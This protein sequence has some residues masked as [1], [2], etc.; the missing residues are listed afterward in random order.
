MDLY[1]EKLKTQ[2]IEKEQGKQLEKAAAAGGVRCPHCGE[3]NEPGAMFCENCGS[4]IESGKC[5]SCGA[6]LPA[7]ADFCEK[8]KSYVAK[9][10]C[11]FC[12][13]SMSPEDAFCPE[14]GAPRQGIVCPVCHTHNMFS[15][16]SICG[17]PLTEM[18]S[19]QLRMV[20][21]EP[22]YARM[23]QIASDLRK[24]LHVIPVTTAGQ[25]EKEKRNE[26]LRNRILGLLGRKL[27]IVQEEVPGAGLDKQALKE[28]IE[29]KRKELQEMLDISKVQPQGS[30]VTARNY[31]MA[32][33]PVGSSL[34]WKCNFKHAIHTGPFGCA[35]PQMGGKWVVLD[36]LTETQVLDD[37]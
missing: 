11:S 17:T 34:G 4:A 23:N 9:N 1:R 13:S 29:Q 16:C 21:M 19:R 7:G 35:C 30:P 27:S 10:I 31:A 26:E 3:M 33:R 37:K 20:Q 22:Q 15:F 18:A 5:P 24:L 12:G 14:C 25:M 32:H 2:N 6:P 36:G 28:L 8:C